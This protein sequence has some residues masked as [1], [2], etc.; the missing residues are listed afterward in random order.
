V[1]ADRRPRRVPALGEQHRVD[2]DVDLAALVGSERLGELHRRR[3]A[4]DRL[5]LEPDRAKLLRQV[6]RVLDSGRVD[7]PRRVLEPLAVEARGGLVQGLVVEH[8]GQGALFEIAADDRHGGD[9]GGR[10]HAQ[11][12]KRRDQ[13]S[14]RGIAERELVYR[15]W[16]TSET[17]FAISCSVAVM[18]M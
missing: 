4:A 6:V 10:R 3:L 11:A 5:G 18:P 2:Q 7:D 16:K 1:H 14:P 15:G 13:S 17:C 12:A 9:R 8:G